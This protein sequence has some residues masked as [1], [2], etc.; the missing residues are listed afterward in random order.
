MAEASEP[1]IHHHH[2]EKTP[3]NLGSVCDSPVTDPGS[4][5]KSIDNTNAYAGR[6]KMD[7]KSGALK[8]S[9]RYRSRSLS[10]SSAD[11]YSS[12][13]YT[14]KIN[15]LYYSIYFNIISFLFCVVEYLKFSSLQDFQCLC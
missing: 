14:G 7:S 2:S 8:K 13:S 3:N 6:S 11:S 15:N 1:N 4:T 9:A 5:V 12:A 10:A